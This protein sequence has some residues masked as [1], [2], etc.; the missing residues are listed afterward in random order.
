MRCHWNGH[1]YTVCYHCNFTRDREIL[2]S[3]HSRVST[4]FEDRLGS[5]Q[6]VNNDDDNQR[7]KAR[8][9]VSDI[10]NCLIN[11]INNIIVI[12]MSMDMES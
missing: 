1:N 5:G 9:V 6:Q 10:T 4:I 12:S 7:E 2:N 8:A 11:I 3:V